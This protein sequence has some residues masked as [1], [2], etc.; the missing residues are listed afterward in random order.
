MVVDAS[1]TKGKRTS[2]SL[3][4]RH[5]D[6]F[7]NCKHPGQDHFGKEFELSRGQLEHNPTLFRRSQNR[8]VRIEQNLACA[9]G[10]RQVK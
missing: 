10:S 2:A 8:F 6:R 1:L 4:K 3:G 5:S 9:G 7:G